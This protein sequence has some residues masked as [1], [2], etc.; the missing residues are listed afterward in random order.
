M[1]KPT[2]RERLNQLK[3]YQIPVLELD[4][5][6]LSN[7]GMWDKLF[8]ST[9]NRYDILGILQ[10]G[11]DSI[12]EYAI[13]G[14]P[15]VGKMRGKLKDIGPENLAT[16][17]SKASGGYIPAQ[18]FNEGRADPEIHAIYVPRQD[19]SYLFLLP[20]RQSMTQNYNP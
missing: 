17:L 2:L 6:F 18:A 12:P 3:E 4:G 1:S 20:S 14:G 8:G 10:D 16:T 13:S 7:N 11:D 19:T 5:S 9:L 15:L